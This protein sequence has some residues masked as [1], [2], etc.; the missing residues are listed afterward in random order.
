MASLSERE[1]INKLRQGKDAWNEWVQ[2]N[3][4]GSITFRNI[5]WFNVFIQQSQP[6]PL[7]SFEG[8]LIPEKGLCF[9][10]VQFNNGILIFEKNKISSQIIFTQCNVFSSRLLFSDCYFKDAELGFSASDVRES[11]IEIVGG[12]CTKSKIYFDGKYRA[13]S[14]VIE[15]LKRSSVNIKFNIPNFVQS[16]CK[17]QKN[18]FSSARI[19]L[20]Q[21]KFDERLEFNDNQ[22][23]SSEID[24]S[25]IIFSKGISFERNDLGTGKIDCSNSKFKSNTKSISSFVETRLGKG[26]FTFHKVEAAQT[27]FIFDGSVFGECEID[28]ESISLTNSDFKFQKCEI[29]AGNFRMNGFIMDS[30]LLGFADSRFGKAS[31]SFRNLTSSAD[32]IDFANCRF[33]G[34]KLSFSKSKF[35]GQTFHFV[36]VICLS[37]RLDFS[38]CTLP[39]HTQFCRSKLGGM[40]HFKNSNFGVENEGVLDFNSASFS[41]NKFDFDDSSFMSR[42][43]SFD[44]VDIA[45]ASVHFQNCSFHGYTH[46]QNLVGVTHSETFTFRGSVFERSLVLSS[47][48]IFG[49]DVTPNVHPFAI[50]VSAS[51]LRDCA[52][53]ARGCVA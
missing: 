9:E 16:K 6:K 28:F 47:S 50:R 35:S 38:L 31:V 14:I 52:G 40:T 45:N 53:E 25:N 8:Y 37:E 27:D 42:F 15:S 43:T 33:E 48:D 46:F 41:D 32:L 21:T 12:N 26:D 3:P 24:L 36:D 34:D 44:N 39:A 1:V 5:S 17:L 10:N 4:E 2:Y 18:R 30:R 51:L 49:C 7:F 22:F 29:E 11:Q 19:D 23:N 20:S 13:S